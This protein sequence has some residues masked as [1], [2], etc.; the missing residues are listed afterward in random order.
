MKTLKDIEKELFGHQIDKYF[1]ENIA[2]LTIEAVTPE[3]PDIEH[4]TDEEYV[5]GFNH[6]WRNCVRA[7]NWNAEQF[8]SKTEAPIKMKRDSGI[9]KEDLEVDKGIAKK[10]KRLIEFHN[11]PETKEWL[12]KANDHLSEVHYGEDRAYIKTEANVQL[13]CE[14]PKY[15]G[16]LSETEEI[17][18]K[19]KTQSETK[20]SVTT[21]RSHGQNI[22]DYE[23]NNVEIDDKGS[24][25]VTDPTKPFSVMPKKDIHPRVE[26][27]TKCDGCGKFIETSSSYTVSE[28][29]QC[30]ECARPKIK[31]SQKE[32]KEII[33]W[34]IG[35]DGKKVY[36]NNSIIKTVN[37]IV[38]HL[39]A[40]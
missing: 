21:D 33:P 6:G 17:W 37:A 34:A 23:F 36:T 30:E 38:R 28:I 20:F 22:G 35:K 39:K 12:T 13:E 1:V 11:S 40:K 14:M 29:I 31:D 15:N 19:P 10:F 9:T 24:M 2:R 25:K 26:N 5:K 8:L 3:N 18:T 16:V 7:A 4:D 27:G 32:V